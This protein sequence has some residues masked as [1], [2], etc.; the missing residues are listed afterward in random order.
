MAFNCDSCT[1][2][3]NALPNNRSPSTYLQS[4]SI[5]FTDD[6]NVETQTQISNPSAITSTSQSI[7]NNV[8]GYARCVHGCKE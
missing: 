4:G 1:L 5:H 7:S 6:L 8:N 3:S 2:H